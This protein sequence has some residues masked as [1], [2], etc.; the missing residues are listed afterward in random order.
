[1]FNPFRTDA[2]SFCPMPTMSKSFDLVQWT[3][4]YCG[5]GWRIPSN[6]TSRKHCDKCIVEKKAE[7][8]WGRLL[9][10][11]KAEISKIS[12]YDWRQRRVKK[13]QLAS[14][15]ADRPRWIRA[16]I[17]EL[18]KVRRA[19][20]ERRAAEERERL[21][22]IQAEER[23]RL[24]K[25]Q[26]EERRRQVGEYPLRTEAA[27]E[28]EEI[29]QA[30]REEMKSWEQ[31]LYLEWMARCPNE[32]FLPVSGFERAQ[33]E[34]LLRRRIAE[35]PGWHPSMGFG[36]PSP[37]VEASPQVACGTDLPP[38]EPIPPLEP[39]PTPA[40]APDPAPTVAASPSTTRRFRRPALA[41]RN[42]ADHHQPIDV[43]DLDGMSGIQFELWLMNLLRKLRYRN[44]K[45]TKQSGD[46]GADIVARMPDA[47][48]IV[49]IQ[50]KRWTKPVGNKAVYEVLGGMR[51]YNATIG[52]VVS[53]SGFTRSA[54]E[55]ASKKPDVKLWGREQIS[56][57]VEQVRVLPPDFD[58]KRYED[59]VL[60]PFF[61][62]ERKRQRALKA[63]QK[64]GGGLFQEDIFEELPC[65]SYPS[66]P[67]GWEGPSEGIRAYENRVV[68]GV[69]KKTASKSTPRSSRR[70]KSSRRGRK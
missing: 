63:Q 13:E 24:A 10:Q 33:R 61:N 59:E 16:R 36:D 38:L 43:R 49:A 64:S 9:T 22:K 66:M 58:P 70:K 11:R 32:R 4:P 12:W 60:R 44:I 15:E 7:V 48:T 56:K 53:W 57:Y 30:I 17:A 25:L 34:K 5:R 1:M 45:Q 55:A 31:R 28:A 65:H 20:A 46:F 54:V 40:K 42:W 51:H 3:C 50:A 47:P 68:H 26:E 35:T 67:D 52:I 18:R 8:E 39:E 41:K 27:I 2:V 69:G 23:E 37:I 29:E 14:F 6:R 19:E 21:A 62:R